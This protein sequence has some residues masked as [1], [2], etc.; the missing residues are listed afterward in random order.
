VKS[1][2]AIYALAFLVATVSCAAATDRA[3]TGQSKRGATSTTLSTI[4]G[5]NGVKY[6]VGASA[7]QVM[8][9]LFSLND[10]SCYWV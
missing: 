2:S 10:W 7:G 3:E 5:Y 6:V 1:I 8:S 9:A 4:R